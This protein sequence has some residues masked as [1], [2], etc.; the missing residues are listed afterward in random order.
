MEA[1]DSAVDLVVEVPHVVVLYAESVDPKVS[2]VKI[3]GDGNSVLEGVGKIASCLAL[4]LEK[5]PSIGGVK[6]NRSAAAPDVTEGRVH[7]REVAGNNALLFGVNEPK[8]G[9]PGSRRR[10]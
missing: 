3:F 6:P 10:A 4:R 1:T 7:P 8:S 5:A 2:K 9:R